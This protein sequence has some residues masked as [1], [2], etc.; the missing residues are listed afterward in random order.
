MIPIRDIKPNVEI[1]DFYFIALVAIT[2]ILVIAAIIF[3][4]KKLQKKH[5]KKKLLEKLKNLDFNNSKKT[6]Y[7]FTELARNFVNE[8]NRVKYEEIVKSLKRYK[9]KKEVPPLSEED[10]EKIKNFIK[11]IRV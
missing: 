6:A 3:A 1:I 9:Y 2:I 8:E 5:P 11:E 4:I 10:R 7:E